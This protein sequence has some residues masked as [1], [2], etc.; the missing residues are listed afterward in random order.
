[1]ALIE[2][3]IESRL[4]VNP[5][6]RAR[7]KVPNQRGS[8]E[9]RSFLGFGQETFRHVTMD[10]LAQRF[11]RWGSARCP[12]ERESFP[13]R[14]NG[15]LSRRLCLRGL[16]GSGIFGILMS[17][18]QS[19]GW[20]GREKED[21]NPLEADGQSGRACPSRLPPLRQWARFFLDWG[22]YH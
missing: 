18:C 8:R 11:G 10:D 12:V 5:T 2:M 13:A 16:E 17:I 4:R 20:P 15:Q 19:G 22:G 1:M 9:R 14:A 21:Q 6:P 3:W 7:S